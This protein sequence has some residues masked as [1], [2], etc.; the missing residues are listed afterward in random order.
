M[1]NK[2]LDGLIDRGYD[3]DIREGFEKGWLM[4]KK[5]PAYASGYTFFV[6]SLQ[7]LFVLYLPD[8]A[9]IFGVFLA[10]PL[11]GGYF[12]AA[13]KISQGELLLYPDFFRGFEYY[14]P[15][16]LVTVV[17]QVLTVVGLFVLVIPGIYLLIAYLF[18]S[19]M[20]LFGGF[21]F[22]PALEYSRKVI[23]IQWFKFLLFGVFAVLLNLAGAMLFLVGLAVTLP[24]TYFALYCIFESITREAFAEE[25]EEVKTV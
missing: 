22:W 4:Y 7:M 18:S 17:G 20:V 9:V 24:V 3:F 15:L 14:V 8:Y 5:Y 16:V 23:Q 19:L 13:N 12:L 10:G 6:I 1:N 25:A 2:K 21:E 11:S